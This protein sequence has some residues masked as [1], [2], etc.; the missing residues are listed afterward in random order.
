MGKENVNQMKIVI[1]QNKEEY[2][3]DHTVDPGLVWEMV[4]RPKI[5]EGFIRFGASKTIKKKKDG[6]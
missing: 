4:K 1:Q 3:R 6:E 2:A 5:R